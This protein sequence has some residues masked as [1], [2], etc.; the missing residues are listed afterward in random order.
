MVWDRDREVSSIW[1]AEAGRL[2]WQIV[3]NEDRGHCAAKADEVVLRAAMVGAGH[4]IASVF[5][6]AAIDAVEY[7]CR[8]CV[9]DSHEIQL[10]LDTSQS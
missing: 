8:V 3:E 6:G 1:A 2:A 5:I 10:P 4:R 9:E 7:R